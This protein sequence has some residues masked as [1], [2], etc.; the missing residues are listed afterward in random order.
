MR[1]LGYLFMGSTELIRDNY[2]NVQ[3]LLNDFIHYAKTELV[4]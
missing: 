2:D 3:E 4:M 1:S